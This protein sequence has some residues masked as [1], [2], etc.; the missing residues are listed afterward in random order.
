[1]PE[2]IFELGVGDIP[3]KGVSG[4]GIGLFYTRKL[5]SDMNATIKFIG[6]ADDLVGAS[7]EIIFK[8]GT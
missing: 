3:P 7:F 8:K 1:M 6:N 4:S 2:K 5:L